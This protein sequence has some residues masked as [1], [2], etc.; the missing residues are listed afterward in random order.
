MSEWHMNGTLVI[1]CNCDWGCPCNFSAPPTHG[2]CEG[3]W[4]WVIDQGAVD[5]VRV[6]GLAFALFADWPGSI[7]EGGGRAVAYIDERADHAQREAL[8]RLLRGDAGGPWGIFINTY[9]LAKPEA[10]RFD[11]TLNDHATRLSIG[12]AVNLEIEPI[13]NPVSGADTHPEM[14]LPEG[15]VLK[16]GSLAASKTFH[17]SGPLEFDHSGKYAAF[18]AFNYQS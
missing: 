16:R 9:Q 12:N 8:A 15:L 14:L 5:G 1:A 7:H 3:G 2:D 6:D 11:V 18:G 4:T 17:E 13:R 10:V